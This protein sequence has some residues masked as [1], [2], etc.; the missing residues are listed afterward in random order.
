MEY[1][2]ARSSTKRGSL[3]TF[4][5]VQNHRCTPLNADA[6]LVRDSVPR[7]GHA[8]LLSEVLMVWWEAMVF[9]VHP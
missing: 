9:R 4:D 3:S 8:L 2:T 5:R 1:L 6:Q 7:I